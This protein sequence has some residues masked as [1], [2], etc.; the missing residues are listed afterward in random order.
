MEHLERPTAGGL[1]SVATLLL[2]AP[3]GLSS[4]TLDHLAVPQSVFGFGERRDQRRV[5]GGPT[6]LLV[7]GNTKITVNDYLAFLCMSGICSV[8]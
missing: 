3:S 4:T 5:Y 2:E 7:K 1:L 8:F 6:K